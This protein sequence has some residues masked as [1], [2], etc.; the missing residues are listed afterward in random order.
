[1]TDLAEDMAR[2]I[3]EKLNGGEFYNGIWY[4]EGHRS[5]WREAVKIFS[6][7]IESLRAEI[8]EIRTGT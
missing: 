8:K 6:D 1:V 5:A 4:S 2:R 3:A 7:E